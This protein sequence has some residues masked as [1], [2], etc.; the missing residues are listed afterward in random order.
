MSMQIVRC[1]LLLCLMQAC[2]P[3]NDKLKDAVQYRIVNHCSDKVWIYFRHSF[4]PEIYKDNLI[5]LDTGKTGICAQFSDV[6]TT[7]Y[8]STFTCGNYAEQLIIYKVNS[9]DTMKTKIIQNSLWNSASYETEDYH[10][11]TC[12]YQITDADF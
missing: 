7:N 12:T 3:K 9:P 4:P 11:K 6:Y 10:V 8:F 1:C 5:V 2:Q